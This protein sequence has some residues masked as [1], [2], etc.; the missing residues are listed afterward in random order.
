MVPGGTLL[1]FLLLLPQ[2][3]QA[4]AVAVRG[5]QPGTEGELSWLFHPYTSLHWRAR[6]S[7]GRR[8]GTGRFYL[9]GCGGISQQGLCACTVATEWS[10]YAGC[11]GRWRNNAKQPGATPAQQSK[12]N[13]SPSFNLED[14]VFISFGFFDNN[15]VSTNC[16]FL[17]WKKGVPSFVRQPLP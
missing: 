17:P 13:G 1:T 3:A 2:L 9:D 11:S 14:V 4:A 10:R 16:S 12:G 15:T 5:R 8:A 7:S 6:S